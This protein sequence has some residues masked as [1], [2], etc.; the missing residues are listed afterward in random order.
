[1]S[2]P[3]EHTFRYAADEKLN[4]H[5]LKL[6]PPY[7]RLS[8]LTYLGFHSS[9]KL[10]SV[11]IRFYLHQQRQINEASATEAGFKKVIIIAATPAVAPSAAIVNRRTSGYF[12]TIRITH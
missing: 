5:Y 2:A 3:L 9:P 6:L 8:P 10:S 12:D 11:G 4:T 1:M 7:E